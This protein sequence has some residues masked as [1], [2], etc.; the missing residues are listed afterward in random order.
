MTWHWLRMSEAVL[1][2]LPLAGIAAWLCWR[3]RYLLAG[4]ISAA[5]IFFAGFI[6]FAG[7]E[8]LEA[9]RY[10]LDCEAGNL[11]CP[12]SEPSDF[13]RIAAYG[14]IAMAQVMCLFLASGS[15]ERRIRDRELDPAWR[16]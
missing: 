10:R 11:P 2:P 14:M 7:L 1:L 5:F 12:P 16:R 3:R 8:F 4:I 6:V 9:F 13:I 15:M